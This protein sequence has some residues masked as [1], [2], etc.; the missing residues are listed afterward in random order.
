MSAVQTH[1]KFGWRPS[2]PDINDEKKLYKVPNITL[3]DS[4]DLDNPSPGP[5]FDPPGEWNQGALGSCGPNTLSELMVY[6]MHKEGLP[7]VIPSRLFLY[8]NTRALMGTTSSDSG[9]DN[10]TMFAALERYGWC[11]EEPINGSPFWPYDVSQF[12]TK[13]PQACY[14]AAAK[15]VQSIKD[16]VVSQDL[17]TMQ[18]C[19]ANSKPFVFGFTVY[20]SMLTAQ[21][22]ATGNVPMPQPGEQVMGGHDILFVGYDNSRQVFKFKNHWLKLDGT[23]W[24]KNGYGTIPYAYALNPNLA[25]DFRTATQV[26]PPPVPP[27]PAP[28]PTPLPP[29]TPDPNPSA[30]QKQIDAIFLAVET[31]IHNATIVAVLKWINSLADAWLMTQ[32]LL[33]ATSVSALQTIIDSMFKDLEASLKGKPGEVMMLKLV[34]KMIDTYLKQH[35]MLPTP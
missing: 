22:E 7:P 23:P 3:P 17:P 27:G 11:L 8:Y 33:T 31:S 14:D 12:T 13:P 1:Y 34:N 5:V 25:S 19:L 6:V 35:Q 24:G 30:L 10:R 15:Y 21:V 18:G 9:V 20:Q 4:V 2:K 28:T 26:A 16:E 29:P 32:N